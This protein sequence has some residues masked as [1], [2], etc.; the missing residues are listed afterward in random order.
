MYA[1]SMN[2]W[3]PY[4][5]MIALL[6]TSM[7]GAAEPVEDDTFHQ[8]HHSH[9]EDPDQWYP[10]DD[11][12]EHDSDSCEHFCHLHAIG[13]IGHIA[14]P[15]MAVN[16][17]FVPRRVFWHHALATAPPTPPPNA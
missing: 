3:I 11:G 2:S 4:L 7:E 6:A 17:A 8:T 5:L 9:A 12:D 10:D 1:N 16:S 13:L 14:L 15:N